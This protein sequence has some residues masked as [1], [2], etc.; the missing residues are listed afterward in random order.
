MS[1]DFLKSP[2]FRSVLNRAYKHEIPLTVLLELTNRC[3]EKCVH[4]Y[5]DQAD[6][7]EIDTAQWLATI[8]TL[9][10]LGTLILTL[11]GGEALLRKDFE[12]IYRHA[13]A[14]KF[15]IRLFT[16]GTM[17]TDGQLDMIANYKPLDV[18]I[19]LYG[20]TAELHDGIT[21]LPGSFDRTIQAIKNIIALEIPVYAKA[22]WMQQN[23]EYYTEIRDFATSLGAVFRGNKNIV[24]TRFGDG[25]SQACQLTDEQYK[26]LIARNSPTPTPDEPPQLDP[27]RDN[28]HLCGA[29]VVTMRIGADGSVYPCTQLHEAAG[30]VQYDHLKNIW[31]QASIFIKLRETRKRDLITC[32]ACSLLVYCFRCPGLA[33][34]EGKTLLGCYSEARRQATIHQAIMMEEENGAQPFR[35]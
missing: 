25:E 31:Q 23:V 32:S 2:L 11:S 4:C 28:S 15:G 34:L 6:R 22:S 29:G 14:R 35:E 8:D 16:N 5:I 24:P 26:N 21:Q 18:Q 9:A 27:K 19:S 7:T 12:A 13:H 33:V 1:E 17:L 3:N 20:H 10:D 30:N